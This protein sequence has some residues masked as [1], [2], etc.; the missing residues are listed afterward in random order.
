M[1]T[2]P[3]ALS[4][5]STNTWIYVADTGTNNITII[6]GSTNA[7]EVASLGAGDEPSGVSFDSFSAVVGVTNY[8][9]DN[10]TMYNG[11]LFLRQFDFISYNSTLGALK[12]IYARQEMLTGTT[13]SYASGSAEAATVNVILGLFGEVYTIPMFRQLVYLEGADNFTLGLTSSYFA[14][15]INATMAVNWVTSTGNE[16]YGGIW[17]AWIGNDTL[18]TFYLV[19]TPGIITVGDDVGG[20]NG[21]NLT[22]AGISSGNWDGIS[23]PTIS[24]S[25]FTAVG[26]VWEAGVTQVTANVSITTIQKAQTGSQSNV[27]NG[28]VIHPDVAAWVGL[29]GN[30]D[31]SG[32][33]MQAGYIDDAAAYPNDTNFFW[34]FFNQN[35]SGSNETAFRSHPPAGSLVGGDQ[36]GEQVV[37]NASVTCFAGSGGCAVSLDYDFNM[38]FKNKTYAEIYAAPFWM[39]TVQS[40]EAIVEAYTSNGWVQQIAR[41]GPPNPVVFAN[42]TLDYYGVPAYQAP[43]PL[44]D[45]ALVQSC[46]TWLIF[47]TTWDLNLEAYWTLN[48]PGYVNVTWENSVYNF[49]CANPGRLCT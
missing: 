3:Y 44:E 20:G 18:G 22:S 42:P 8:D 1:G 26:Q 39:A 6:N 32:G 4:Y 36:V 10:F 31:G 14:G 11:S 16:N 13:Y 40:S 9:S 28:V 15:A 23:W 41:L 35:G 38:F 7:V 43:T 5:D 2:S 21:G 29:S 33:L 17:N 30:P 34:Q 25:G 45:W 24:K 47:C 48:G 49:N 27:P 37:E 46:Q 19:T 12:V